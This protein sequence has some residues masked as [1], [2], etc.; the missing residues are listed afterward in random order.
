[1]ELLIQINHHRS[2]TVVGKDFDGNDMIKQKQENNRT[3]YSLEKEHP[4]AE[5]GISPDCYVR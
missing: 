2:R 5:I 1:M 4:V 3:A